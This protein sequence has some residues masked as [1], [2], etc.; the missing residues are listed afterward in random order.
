MLDAGGEP[1]AFNPPG[2][3]QHSTP[4]HQAVAAGHIDVVRLLV[5]RGARI[6]LEDTVYHATPLAWAEHGG[7]RAI[8]DYLRGRAGTRG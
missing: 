1:D 2:H 4:L 7:H 8:A 6:D 5:E 3:H